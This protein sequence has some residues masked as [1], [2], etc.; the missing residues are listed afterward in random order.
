MKVLVIGGTRFVGPLLVQRLLAAGHQVTLFNRGT[1]PDP[2][3]AR[4]ERLQGDRTTAD[5]ARLLQN[6]HFDAAV[7]FAAYRAEDTRGAVDALGGRVGHYVFI[8]TGQ[9]YLVR[10]GAPRPSRE[11]DYA[12]PVMP[13]PTDEDELGNWEYGTG[14]RDCED[15][16]VEAFETSR[17]PST[18]IRI[19][20]VNGE[21]DSSRRIDRY[22]FRLADGG[23]VL[24]PDGGTHLVRHVYAGEV[25][26]FL[27]DIL[28]NARTFGEAYNVCQPEMP[29][30][31]ELLG[32][33][34]GML[35]S[36]SELAPVPSADVVAA[37]LCLRD[38]SPF[39]TKWMS[40]V[41][42]SKAEAELGFRH[43]PLT[44]SLGKIVASFLAYGYATP[45]PDGYEHRPKEIELATRWLAAR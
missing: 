40:M 35:G 43:E 28:G 1:L 3:G 14:K 25:A 11:I 26:R 7:D 20:V 4:I 45:P 37:G 15:T 36:R 5:L 29:S 6:R 31:V 23:P 8:S 19:P 22:L 39:S 34:K 33:L 10:E 41:D 32:I 42:P 21:R 38:V 27:T 13:R 18:R 9:V 24:V 17:F 30:L 12:G 16:L 2:F 44:T